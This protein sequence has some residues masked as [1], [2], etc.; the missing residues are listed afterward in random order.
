LP[1]FPPEADRLP[2]VLHRA[3]L[4]N[5]Q[6]DPGFLGECFPH[7]PEPVKAQERIFRRFDYGP[8]RLAEGKGNLPPVHLPAFLHVH[9]HRYLPCRQHH[10][11]ARMGEVKLRRAFSRE[12]GFAICADAERCVRIP[13]FLLRQRPDHHPAHSTAEAVLPAHKAQRFLPCIDRK[14]RQHLLQASVQIQ[15]PGICNPHFNVQCAASSPVPFFALPV[16]V[17]YHALH[18]NTTNNSLCSFFDRYGMM[19][20]FPIDVSAF[21]KQIC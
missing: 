19:Y 4:K 14:T 10:Q 16:K 3:L 21:G 7:R 13:Q 20:L 1:G 8:L 9:A 18:T 6:P 12:E 17:V 11:P 15:R 5:G 2:A